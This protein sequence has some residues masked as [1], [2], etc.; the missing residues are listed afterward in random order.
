MCLFA[1]S[2]S[3]P[4]LRMENRAVNHA[5]PRYPVCRRHHLP[6]H[7]RQELNPITII[8]SFSTVLLYV[9]LGL[10][11]LRFPSGAHVRATRGRQLLSICS[12]C[13]MQVHLLFLTSSLMVS[14]LALLRTS[15]LDARRPVDSYA[16]TCVERYQV[17][18]HHPWPSS[19]IHNHT[20]TQLLHLI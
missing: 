17:W 18:P 11:L 7:K 15:S 1:S 9:S 13:S 6:Q 16:G 5:P 4:S 12:T 10:P 20:A 3:V 8:L 2:S 19:M 14:V